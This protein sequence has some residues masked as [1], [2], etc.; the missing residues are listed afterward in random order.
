MANANISET[1]VRSQFKDHISTK[2]RL[3]IA[4]SK[5]NPVTK[6]CSIFKRKSKSL[7]VCPSRST[8][9]SA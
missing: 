5:K 7:S 1:I 4:M 2:D 8:I 9:V 6:C 3:M